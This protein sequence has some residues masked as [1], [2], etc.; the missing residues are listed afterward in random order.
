[1][2]RKVTQLRCR[3]RTVHTLFETDAA[4]FRCQ[5][6]QFERTLCPAGSNFSSEK[7]LSQD[8]GLLVAC[9]LAR[10]HWSTM[11]KS[12]TRFRFSFQK[13]DKYIYSYGK[14]KLLRKKV[15]F[16][17]GMT[18]GLCNLQARPPPPPPGP[19]SNPRPRHVK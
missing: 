11:Q 10:N 14:P 18:T 9:T 16:P 3:Q 1:M 15:I 7:I 5:N 4:E 2:Q 13:P 6:Y 17:M 19:C 12:S 8:Q